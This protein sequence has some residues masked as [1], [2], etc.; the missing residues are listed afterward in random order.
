MEIFGYWNT[1]VVTPIPAMAE[2]SGCFREAL[3]THPETV[4]LCIYPNAG[5][6]WHDS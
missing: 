3:A 1:S 4:R 2:R 5:R 6:S